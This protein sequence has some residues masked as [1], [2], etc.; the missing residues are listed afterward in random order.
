MPNYNTYSLTALVYRRDNEMLSDPD[1]EDLL[2]HI[3]YRADLTTY[4]NDLIER[5]SAGIG[6]NPPTPP[7]PP[8]GV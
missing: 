5:A 7:P 1:R 2:D 8:P 3:Q 4:A 6:S